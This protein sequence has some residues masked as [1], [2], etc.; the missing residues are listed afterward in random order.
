ML[1]DKYRY[2]AEPKGEQYMKDLESFRGTPSGQKAEYGTDFDQNIPMVE[3]YKNIMYNY[4]RYYYYLIY[5]VS[6]NCSLKII[7]KMLAL[8]LINFYAI[9]I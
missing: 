2:G 9:I 6:N 1:L 3:N 7:N 4:R 8:P 5:Y